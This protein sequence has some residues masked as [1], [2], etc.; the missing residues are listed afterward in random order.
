MLFLLKMPT[1]RFSGVFRASHTSTVPFT[2]TSYDADDL[3]KVTFLPLDS[4][5]RFSEIPFKVFTARQCQP[6]VIQGVTLI[7]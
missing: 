4:S 3:A 7:A 1:N 2:E 6:L 5:G